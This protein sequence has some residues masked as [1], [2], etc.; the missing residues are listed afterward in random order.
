[1]LINRNLFQVG[2]HWLQTELYIV[3]SNIDMIPIN[4]TRDIYLS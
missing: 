2:H 1:M 4:N 3:N